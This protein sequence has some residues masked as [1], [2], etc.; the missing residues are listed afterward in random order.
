MTEIKEDEKTINNFKCDLYVNVTFQHT[1]R[2]S[3]NHCEDK[4]TSVTN[5]NFMVTSMK[6]LYL[7]MD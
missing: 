1:N 2:P 3:V 6:S 5:K 4:N 7:Q